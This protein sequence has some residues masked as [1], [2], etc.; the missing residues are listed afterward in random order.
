M[1]ILFSGDSPTVNTG[2][3]I[4]AKNIVGRLHKRGYEMV[5]LGI[6][7]YGDPYDPVEFPYPIYPCEKGAPDQVFGTHKL[8]A[9]AKDFQPDLLFFLNDPW[10]IE[11]Y[12]SAKD[13]AS[14]YMK[15]IAYYPI[16]AGPL[17]KSWASTLSEL[18]AQICYSEFGKRIITEANGGKTPENLHQIY[19]GVNRKVFFPVNQQVARRQ[20]GIPEDAFIV[21]MVARN[22]YRK[23]FDILMKSFMEFAKDKPNAKLYLHTAT[24]DI[25]FDI[26]ELSEQFNMGDRLILTEGVTAAQGVPEGFLNLIYN[27]FD[28]N[29]LISL[30]DGFGLPVAESMATG[31]PQL[32]S[33]HS[34]L[35]ELVDGHGGLTVKNAAWLMNTAGINTWGGLSDE[36]DLVSKLNILYNSPNLRVKLAEDGYA[37]ISQPKFDWDIAADQFEKII[38]DVFHLIKPQGVAA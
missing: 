32:V 5:V 3:G 16:D 30:G 29:A 23:R 27:S 8:W 24:R 35:K 20:L 25:G 21:G 38:A 12:I 17:K 34:C 18:D 6:N 37:F 26:K 14:P 28:V 22:Q 33:D 10:V 2:F 4:V 9:I 15:T 31:C 19:H 1:R 13:V 11:R 7:M 36:E